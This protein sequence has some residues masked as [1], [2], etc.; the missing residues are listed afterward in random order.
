MFMCGTFE[1]RARAAL[2]PGSSRSE[3]GRHTFAAA[4]KAPRPIAMAFALD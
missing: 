1:G 4:Q 3:L 2:L